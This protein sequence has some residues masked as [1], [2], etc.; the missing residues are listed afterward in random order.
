MVVSLCCGDGSLVI[1]APSGVIHDVSGTESAVA[2]NF[3]NCCRVCRQ[4]SEATKTKTSFKSTAGGNFQFHLCSFWP[5]CFSFSQ[6]T[7][8]VCF[9]DDYDHTAIRTEQEQYHK[10]EEEQEEDEEEPTKT[11]TETQQQQSMNKNKLT[12]TKSTN[13]NISKSIN[14]SNNCSSNT[15]NKMSNHISLQCC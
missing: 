3:S 4:L 10:E 7:F 14:G 13:R 2:T 12:K 5:I 8:A 11:T 9:G 1:V 15:S 6:I